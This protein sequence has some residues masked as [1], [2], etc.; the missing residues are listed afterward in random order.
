MRIF[1]IGE[2]YDMVG[3]KMNVT[4]VDKVN[5]RGDEVNNGETGMFGERR[6]VYGWLLALD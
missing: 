4:G 6:G 1:I 5:E 2:G 3:K